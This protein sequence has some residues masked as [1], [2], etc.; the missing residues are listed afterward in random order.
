M[1]DSIAK[2]R[3][4][5][6]HICLEHWGIEMFINR[7]FDENSLQNYTYSFFSSKWLIEHLQNL[8]DFAIGFLPGRKAVLVT[9][10][11]TKVSWVIKIC[12]LLVFFCL[13]AQL[14]I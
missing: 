5:L 1:N 4:P 10:F 8:F 14:F 3:L 13:Y 7:N 2:L 11:G 12:S 6:N 9:F